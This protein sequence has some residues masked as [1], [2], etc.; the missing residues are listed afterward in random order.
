MGKKMGFTER[1]VGHM[2]FC[3]FDKLYQAYKNI[4][5]LE[6][7]LKYN[8]TTYAELEKEETLDDAIPF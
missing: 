3:K 8:R 6:N 1:Q 4:F 2:T 7:K 5:D